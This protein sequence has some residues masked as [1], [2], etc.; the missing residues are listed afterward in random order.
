MYHIVRK[1]H[2]TLCKYFVIFWSLWINPRINTKF[3]NNSRI[4]G[5]THPML[6]QWLWN[7]LHHSITYISTFLNRMYFTWYT[8]ACRLTVTTM[9]TIYCSIMLSEIILVYEATRVDATLVQT[10]M[11]FWGAH[12]F[13]SYILYVLCSPIFHLLVSCLFSCSY[14]YLSQVAISLLWCKKAIV[15]V[16]YAA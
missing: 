13:C 2:G 14:Q 3:S 9:N 1:A 7:L 12:V 5:Q 6:G 15:L 10:A 8:A 16:C 4:Y 11:W